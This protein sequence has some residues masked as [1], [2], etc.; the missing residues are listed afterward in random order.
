M[1]MFFSV[2]NK[3]LNCKIKNDLQSQPITFVL[4]PTPRSQPQFSLPP[5]LIKFKQIVIS[6]L[7]CEKKERKKGKRLLPSGLSQIMRSCHKRIITRAWLCLKK[8]IEKYGLKDEIQVANRNL[9]DEPFSNRGWHILWLD[10][11]FQYSSSRR[12]VQRKSRLHI[13]P[14]K[15]AKLGFFN[16]PIVSIHLK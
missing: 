14:Y 13:P 2:K 8:R 1:S 12:L 3:L 10:G 7:M 16:Y 11:K 9:L 4:L 5:L 6:N 15:S